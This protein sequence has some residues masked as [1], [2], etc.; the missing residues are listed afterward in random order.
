MRSVSLLS[1]LAAVTAVHASPTKRAITPVTAK[2]N[3]FY[4][5][6][7]RFYVRGVDYQPGGSSGNLDPLAEPSI[8]KPGIEKL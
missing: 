5:G 3:A 1:A 4:V 7:E 8:C 6:S 2:G